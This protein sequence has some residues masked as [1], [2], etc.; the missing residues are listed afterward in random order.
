MLV[1]RLSRPFKNSREKR[2]TVMNRAK[3]LADV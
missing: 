1:A 3:V 2:E